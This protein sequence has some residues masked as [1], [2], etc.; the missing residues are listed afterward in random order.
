MDERLWFSVSLRFEFPSWNLFNIY[1]STWDVPVVFI[2][3]AWSS[4]ISLSVNIEIVLKLYLLVFHFSN[5]QFDNLCLSTCMYVVPNSHSLYQYVEQVT[6]QLCHIPRHPATFRAF[7][8]CVLDH[9][10]CLS[11]SWLCM[12]ERGP[13]NVSQALNGKKA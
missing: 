7:D 9:K 5:Q 2:S 11:F 8:L 6:T 12:G 13:I 4:N 1:T 3:S 10:Y